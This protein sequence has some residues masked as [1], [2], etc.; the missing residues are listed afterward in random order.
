MLPLILATVIAVATPAD[1]ARSAWHLTASTEYSTYVDAQAR[2][3]NLY[4]APREGYGVGVRI[5]ATR[6]FD[7]LA[8]GT[9]LSLFPT[10]SLSG[11]SGSLDFL[12]SY[13]RHWG[14]L[15]LV[16]G[17]G[18]GVFFASDGTFIPTLAGR[19]LGPSAN[20]TA[21]LDWY[22]SAD[23]FIALGTGVHV[24]PLQPIPTLPVGLDLR[25]FIGPGVAF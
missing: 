18:I 24:Y 4:G 20:A 16:A 17:G 5:A 2:I 12:A 8:L 14:P 10:L 15:R 13:D 21:E 9:A 7:R 25:F 3:A 22:P 19:R 23:L 1:A 6:T 11:A